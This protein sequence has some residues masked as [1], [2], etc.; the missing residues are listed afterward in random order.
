MILMF[1]VSFIS[2]NYLTL[3]YGRYYSLCNTKHLDVKSSDLSP[4]TDRKIQQRRPENWKEIA[5][6]YL[7]EKKMR[8]TIKEFK[9]LELNDSYAYWSVIICRWAKDVMNNKTEY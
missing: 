8:P 9:L 7:T 3:I 5:E 4:T 6:Y 2:N 1:F